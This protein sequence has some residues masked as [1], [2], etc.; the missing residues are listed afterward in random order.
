MNNFLAIDTSSRYL[1]VLAVKGEKK[2]LKYLDDCAMK[3]SV[4]LM[5]VIDAAL[6]EA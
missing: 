4:K 2:V 1:T 6:K 3:H 5:G